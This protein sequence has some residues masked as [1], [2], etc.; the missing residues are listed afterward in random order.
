MRQVEQ[1]APTGAP[2]LILGE[3][4]TGKEVVARAIHSRSRRH[5]GPFLRVNCGAIPPELVDSELF[6]HE[7]GSFTGAVRRQTGRPPW[8][9]SSNWTPAMPLPGGRWQIA[10]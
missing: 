5:A 7:K 9:P 2:V 10:R 6:G 4:G 1:V 3:T 8:R